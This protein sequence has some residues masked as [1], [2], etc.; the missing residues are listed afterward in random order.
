MDTI[1]DTIMAATGWQAHYADVR[2]M[3][4]YDCKS[5]FLEGSAARVSA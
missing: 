5:L 1:T 2:I 4:T 3:L